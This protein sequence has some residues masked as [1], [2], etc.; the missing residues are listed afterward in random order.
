MRRGEALMLR[1]TPL[2]RGSKPLRRSTR[3]RARG[4]TKYRRR[5]RDFEFM[6]WVKKQPCIA[7]SLPP[8]RFIA[9]TAAERW[10]HATQTPCTGRVEADHAGE[11]GIGQKADDRT[12]IP[13]C[14]R[15]HRERT[16]HSFSFKFLVRD[17][18]RAWRAEAITRTQTAWEQR[19]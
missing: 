12:C 7:R 1:R 14:T 16:D 5:E 11:R 17:E 13:L 18:L 6:G 10:L 3:L 8:L 19:R 4:N 9:A 2:A 15:H